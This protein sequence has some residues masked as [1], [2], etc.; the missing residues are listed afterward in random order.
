MVTGEAAASPSALP[1]LAQDAR[2]PEEALDATRRV[3]AER[4]F[5][6]DGVG[7]IAKGARSRKSDA[8]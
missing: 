2:Y 1:V 7:K 8:R 5:E 6:V 3:V 4:S